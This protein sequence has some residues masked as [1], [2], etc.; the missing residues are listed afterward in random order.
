MSEKKFFAIAF[1]TITSVLGLL[2]GTIE[3]MVKDQCPR[4]N[5][6]SYYPAYF[7]GCELGKKRF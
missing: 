5:L 1:L 4:H 6:L 7:I 3:S 2:I